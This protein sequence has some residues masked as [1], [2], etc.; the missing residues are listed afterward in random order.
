MHTDASI[1]AALASY[2][3]PA[4]EPDEWEQAR[5]VLLDAGIIAE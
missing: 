3:D 2:N 5:E 4:T 1:A